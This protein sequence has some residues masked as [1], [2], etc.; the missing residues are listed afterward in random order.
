MS[1][2]ETLIFGEVG[3]AIFLK[4]DKYFKITVRN[5][6]PVVCNR[7][8]IDVLYDFCYE[9]PVIYDYVIPIDELSKILFELYEKYT[10]LGFFWMG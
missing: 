3:T 2:M 1:Q 6:T 9:S 8:D 10:G 4:D 7:Y 5:E